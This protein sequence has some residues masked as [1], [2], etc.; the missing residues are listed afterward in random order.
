M[1]DTPNPR[2]PLVIQTGL[3]IGGRG[4]TG[5][6][7][8]SDPLDNPV[9]GIVVLAD[10]DLGLVLA[11]GTDND[12]ALIPVTAGM[13]FPFQAIAVSGSNTADVLGVN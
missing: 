6:P 13:Y 7:M 4:F 10:G 8:S 3:T 12:S 9:S 11:D 1:T 2:S 5:M